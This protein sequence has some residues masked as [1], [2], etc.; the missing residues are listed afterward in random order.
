MARLTPQQQAEKWQRNLA[1]A[2]QDITN[3]VNNVTTN[4][5]EQAILAKDKMIN[6][7]LDSVNNGKWERGLQN[8][9]LQGWKDA[10]INKGVQRIQAGAQAGMPKYLQ[11][12]NDVRP[13]MDSLQ[14][15]VQAMPSLTI[16]DSV[17][18]AAA[19]IRGMSQYSRS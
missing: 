9:T 11:Y 19:W 18:R 7:W 14:A 3:G 12:V 5:A 1:A 4:P 17:N 15:Q 8:T 2:G 10:M 6:N 13:F 16:E